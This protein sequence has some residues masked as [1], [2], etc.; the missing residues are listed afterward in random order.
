MH[1][2]AHEK[3]AL[4]ENQSINKL[5]R[6]SRTPDNKKD[7]FEIVQITALQKQFA[8]AW[9]CL[10]GWRAVSFGL[11]ERLL[12]CVLVPLELTGWRLCVRYVH[13]PKT[14]DVQTRERTYTLIVNYLFVWLSFFLWQLLLGEHVYAYVCIRIQR[15][16]NLPLLY[17]TTNA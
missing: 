14:H 13:I 15:I 17:T 10:K 4:K 9:M 2:C 5:R 6:S 7:T 1:T 3:F 16:I 8:S 12:F 11:K